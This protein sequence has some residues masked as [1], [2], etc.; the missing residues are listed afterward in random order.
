MALTLEYYILSE[1][2]RGHKILAAAAFAGVKVGERMV[3]LPTPDAYKRNCSPLGGNPVLETPEG[4]I[5]ESNAILRYIARLDKTNTLYGK[6]TYENS[7]VDA[8]LDLVASETD[9][10]ATHVFAFVRSQTAYPADFVEVSESLFQSIDNWLETRTFLVGER[11]TIADIN[12]AFTLQVFYRFATNAEA[13]SKKFKNVWRLYNTVMQQPQ[14]VEVLK[15]VG[16]SFGLVAKPKEEKKA[17]PK[18]EK[19]KEE[20]NARAAEAGSNHASGNTTLLSGNLQQELSNAEKQKLLPA[21][22]D[23]FKD[24][25]E[26]IIQYGYV[27]LF[28]VA[29]PL[30]PLLALLNN[31]AEIR[32]DAFKLTVLH[33]RPLPT[34]AEDIGSW[35]YILD[36]MTIMSVVTNVGVIAFTSGSNS[37]I[38]L[39]D[40]LKYFIIWEHVLLGIKF[41]LKILIPDVPRSIRILQKRHEFVI[42]K[43]I[44]GIVDDDEE[45]VVQVQEQNANDFKAKLKI[46]PNDDD[47]DE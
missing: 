26:M 46:A 37:V 6:T 34:K 45:V 28:T 4:Y 19:K 40:R 27:T 44:R 41:L 9:P 36:I 39:Y 31:V 8:W 5:F 3:T 2:Y 18:A 30:A 24:Y 11:Q 12:L 13:L 17:E 29:F 38:P 35:Y 42:D 10:L 1:N 16:G 47:V 25:D 7:M 22:D 14:T 32:L 21:Y 15:S 33:R 43:Y 20:K 23:T